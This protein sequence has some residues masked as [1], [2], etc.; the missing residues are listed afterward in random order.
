MVAMTV[1]P[2][3]AHDTLDSVLARLLSLDR[4]LTVD[5][6]EQLW[7]LDSRYRFELD[8][9]ALVVSAA[10][11]RF[12]Q[13]A[14]TRLATVL[15]NACPLG[16]AVVNAPDVEISPTHVRIPDTVVV[17]SKWFNPKYADTPPVLA[18]EIASPSTRAY[19][20]SRK[21]QVYA[22]FGIENYWIITPD[23]KNPDI[24]V[25]TLTGKQYTQADYAAGDKTFT[26][27]RPFLVSFTPAQLVNIGAS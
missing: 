17:P 21:K 18:V 19:D 9:G 4:P 12:H 27:S 1:P 13:L 15:T 10:P 8:E 16:F 24:T 5:D 7:Q 14:A 25:F 3:E 11:S 20:R 22:E 23:Q 2:E 26:A 6:L